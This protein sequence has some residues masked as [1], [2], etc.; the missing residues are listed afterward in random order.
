MPSHANHIGRL[1]DK[2][3]NRFVEGF[4]LFKPIQ[5]KCLNNIKYLIFILYVRKIPSI[6]QVSRLKKYMF[7]YNIVTQIYLT[8]SVNMKIK[9]LKKHG[10]RY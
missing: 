4:F 5:S 1:R 8:R 9:F 2:L 10:Y 3:V 6:L 7:V